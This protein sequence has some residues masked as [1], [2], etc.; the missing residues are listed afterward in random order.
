MRRF[1][2]TKEEKQYHINTLE[3]YACV[4]TVDNFYLQK[5]GKNADFYVDNSSA[6]SWLQNAEIPSSVTRDRVFLAEQLQR[7][8]GA[9][10]KYDS[11]EFHRV[12]TK[13]FFVIEYAL[14]FVILQFL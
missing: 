9:L 12:P 10:L 14:F 8:K 5:L 11:V 4:S 1:Y 6:L 2:F 3:F 7:L 13:E